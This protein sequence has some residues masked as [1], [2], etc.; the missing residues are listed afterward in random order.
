MEE[1]KTIFE[2]SINILTEGTPLLTD[3][4]QKEYFEKTIEYLSRAKEI[5]NNDEKTALLDDAAVKY[6]NQLCFILFRESTITD[7]LT[8]AIRALITPEKS[9]EIANQYNQARQARIDE[10]N[11]QHEEIVNEQKDLDVFFGVI[12]GKTVAESQAMLEQHAADIQS[13]M[14][15]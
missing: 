14:N 15:Q 2:E 6:A 7:E 8:T 9:S 12:S 5:A 4:A 13:Q 1:V 10:L 11:K 3:D